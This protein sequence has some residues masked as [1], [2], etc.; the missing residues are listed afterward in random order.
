MDAPSESHPGSQSHRRFVGLDVH[1]H[2]VVVGA[3]D[4]QQQ[5]VL[6]PRR[7][8][9]DDFTIWANKHLLPT[10]AVVMESTTN[11][12]HLV[13]QLQPLVA[14]VVVAHPLKV[15]L[16][17][18]ARVKTDALD[19]LRLA[20]LLAANLIPQVW[21]PPVP[22][23]E[24]R[25][26]ISHRRRLLRQQ[27]QLRNRLHSVLHC[28]NLLPPGGDLFS[29]HHRAWWLQLALSP[30]NKLLVRQDLTLLDTIPTLITEVDKE[31]VQLSVTQPW[32]SITPFLVQ[33]PGIGPL[34]A[35]TL[36]GEIGDI[37]RFPSAKHLVSY[38]GLGASVHS[39]GQTSRTGRIT[40]QGRRELRGTLVEAAWTAVNYNDYWRTQFERLAVRIGKPKAIV[41]MARKL[42]VVIWHVWTEEAMDRHADADAVARKFLAWGSRHR[43]AKYT[44]VKRLV[45]VGERLEQVGL[46]G[47]VG[48]IREGNYTRLLPVQAVLP[49]R[50][51]VPGC[52]ST[53]S[54]ASPPPE[55]S[56]LI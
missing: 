21:V 23:R 11:T 42:L 33:L 43:L 50:E 35:M 29:Q 28:H 22:V 26:L 6:R 51:I 55:S 31:L 2:F 48:A 8:E 41:A 5:V 20:T 18:T 16:I 13:D 44:G 47:R 46:G 19:A 38:A 4:A 45:F 12:W 17:A 25:A 39:S 40:K 56:S 30:S 15:R 27:T 3:V 10:D 9:F 32:A 49:D 54:R 24:L 52:T 1:K 34:N 7:L 36:L 14:S 53:V 37:Q